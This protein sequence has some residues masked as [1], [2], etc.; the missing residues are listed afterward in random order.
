MSAV[1]WSGSYAGKTLPEVLFTDPDWFFDALE[2]GKFQQFQE[3]LVEEAGVLARKARNIRIR[4]Q[5]HD[6]WIVQYFFYPE[7]GF[8]RFDIIRADRK[9]HVGSSRVRYSNNINM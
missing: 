5:S 4:K 9:P 6:K 1:I 3:E 7:S 2:N 8:T